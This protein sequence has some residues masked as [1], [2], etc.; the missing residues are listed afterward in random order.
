MNHNI[1]FNFSNGTS[2]GIKRKTKLNEKMRS[3]AKLKNDQQSIKI[4]ILHIFS[5]SFKMIHLILMLKIKDKS[6]I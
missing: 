1:Y 3:L 4:L 2:L 6:L 5:T